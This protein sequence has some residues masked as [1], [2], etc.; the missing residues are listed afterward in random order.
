MAR[1]AAPQDEFCPVHAAIQ[2]LQE[3]WVLHIIR[4]LLEGPRGFNELSRLVGGCNPATLTQRLCRLE[5]LGLLSKTV[6]SY[7]PPRT[8]YNLTPAG[9][10][11][12][13]V[14]DAIARWGTEH[15]RPDEDGVRV[16]EPVT[17]EGRL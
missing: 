15:L 6:H 8:T 10:S 11:L 13:G 5:D 9:V 16:C 1:D 12:Q 2:I 7:M 14:V 17:P 3:K 4:A